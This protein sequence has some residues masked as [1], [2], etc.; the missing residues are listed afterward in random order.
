MNAFVEPASRERRPGEVPRSPHTG[1]SSLSLVDT[2]S[3]DQTKA[4]ARARSAHDAA[5]DAE[6]MSVPASTFENRL[7]VDIDELRAEI[8][9]SPRERVLAIVFA[10]FGTGICAVGVERLG[11]EPLGPAVWLPSLAGLA[12][13]IA[14]AWLWRSGGHL[15]FDGRSR[16]FR[17]TGGALVKAEHVTERVAFADV[18]AV[19]HLHCRFAD[20]EARWT[21]HQIN[22]VCRD[23]RR[24]HVCSHVD[25]DLARA[26]ASRIAC[27]V[28][29]DVLD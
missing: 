2:S 24:V 20:E 6:P 25:A 19:Q 9:G 3:R 10:A 15:V 22:L 4:T 26:S 12:M 21:V 17:R 8:V 28:G 27:L 7:L 29:V 23:D 1:R 14:G 11:S 13:I 18:A 5:I 16:E